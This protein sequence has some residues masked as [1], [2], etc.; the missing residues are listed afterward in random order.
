MWVVHGRIVVP[1]FRL[2]SGLAL[3]QLEFVAKAG[4]G[5]VF[6]LQCLGLQDGLSFRLRQVVL[7]HSGYLMQRTGGA[8]LDTIALEHVAVRTLGSP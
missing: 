5:L 1:R 3:Q 7:A 4:D 6:L 8:W 2:D